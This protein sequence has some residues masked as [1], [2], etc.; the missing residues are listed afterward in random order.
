MKRRFLLLLLFLTSCASAPATPPVAP[1]PVVSVS[2][3]PAAQP[4]LEDV[5]ACGTER[6][7][8]IRLPV[9]E[10]AAD[11]RLQLGEPKPLKTRAYQIGTEDILVVTGRENPLQNLSEAET[12]NLFSKS[13]EDV[14]VWVYA[15]SADAQEIFEQEVMRGTRIHTFARL[16][17]HPHQL[18]DKLKADSTAIGI[19]PRRWMTGTMRE[20]FQVASVPVLVITSDEPQ[21]A[22][23]ALIAC[24]Q[25]KE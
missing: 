15:F 2:A 3:S 24:L 1:P 9:S 5:Y 21:G 16:A 23:R 6:S 7:I 14:E 17:L 22:I 8:V 4:W 12:R 18:V 13:G 10:S 25:R 11:I 20:V 19:L